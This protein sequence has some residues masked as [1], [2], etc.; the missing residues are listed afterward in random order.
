[1]PSNSR[2]GRGGTPT[3]S[4]SASKLIDQDKPTRAASKDSLKQKM[5]SKK[6][7][8]TQP[9]RADEQLK[10]LKSEFDSLRSH[11]TCKICDR[12]LYQPY[13]IS[14]GHTY[15]YTCLCTWFVA[16]KA[17]KTCPDCRIVVKDLPAPAYVVSQPAYNPSENI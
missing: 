1:M 9:S 15:C 2:A 10:A 13:T 17:R 14:C 4:R 8:P 11:L 7:E 5:L 3:A 6:D 12:L 16:N